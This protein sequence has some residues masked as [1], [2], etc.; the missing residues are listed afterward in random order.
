M[1]DKLQLLR[2]GRMRFRFEPSAEHRVEIFERP[3][4]ELSS[5]DLAKLIESCRA[6]ARSCLGGRDL[7]YGLFDEGGDALR[8]SVITLVTRVADNKPV[9]F[10]AMPILQVREG[11]QDR[12]LVHLGLVMVDPDERSGGL[13]WILYGLTCFA[14]FVRGRMRPLWVSSVTQVP[15]VVGMVADTFSN[16]FPGQEGTGQSFAHRHFAHQI[17]QSHRD[18][19]GVGPDAGFV[20][21]RQVITDAYTGGSDNLKKSFAVAAKHRDDSYNDFCQRELDYERGD[22]VLQI[23]VIDLAA[24]QRFLMRS[25]PRHALPRLLVRAA[26][27]LTAAIVS[28]LLQWL[29]SSTPLDRLRPAR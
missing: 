27:L 14:M 15:A 22:D 21:E 25:V 9:A 12:Q 24:G 26:V 29:D 20:L 7:D 28:P 13:S 17:M 23:G 8:R 10:N 18:A 4:D 2:R 5:A 16:V 1:F 11:G 6:V 3:A 19:F